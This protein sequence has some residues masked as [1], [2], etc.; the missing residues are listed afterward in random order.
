MHCIQKIL[1]VLLFS[2][3]LSYAMKPTS[4]QKH[5][6]RAAV[7]FIELIKKINNHYGNQNAVD[8]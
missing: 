1:C 6:H 3:L 5:A 8:L 2:S 7:S 4:D